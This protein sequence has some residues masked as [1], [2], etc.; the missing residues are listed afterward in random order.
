MPLASIPSDRLVPIIIL[1][2][3]LRLKKYLVAF[4]LKHQHES[5][6]KVSVFGTSVL[7]RKKH[8]FLPL[9]ATSHQETHPGEM[10]GLEPPLM[11]HLDT[12]LQGMVLLYSSSPLPT[13][14]PR[15]NISK[16]KQQ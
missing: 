15:I 13:L 7:I 6:A 16:Q 1:D 12:L 9:E 10:T 3:C 4:S 11:F 2:T 14:I 8:F 5:H